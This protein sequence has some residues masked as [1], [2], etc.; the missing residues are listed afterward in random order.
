VNDSAALALAR[1]LGQY[2]QGLAAEPTRLRSLLQ[3]ECPE[4][5]RQIAALMQAIEEGIP[6]DLRRVHS[7]EPVQSVASRL[8]KRLSDNRALAR[9]A[10][11]WAVGAWANALGIKL[12]A[13]A[14]PTPVAR[15]DEW[16]SADEEPVSRRGPEQPR[17]LERDRE[18]A[19]GS[20]R[21]H[22]TIRKT[23]PNP[24][25]SVLSA[26]AARWRGLSSTVQKA[27]GGGA[28]AVVAIVGW[29]SLSGSPLAITR[30]DMTETFVGDG[31]RREVQMEFSARGAALRS[32]D[33]RFVRGD[34]NWNPASWSVNLPADAAAKGRATLGTMSF[35][36]QRPASATFE[37]VLVTADGRRSA[38]FEKTFEIQ[39][40]PSTP[41]RITSINLPGP[42]YVGR[43]FTANIAFEDPDGD[44]AKVERRVVESTSA[45]A[46]DLFTQDA[47]G[48]QG[49]KAG[50]TTYTFQAPKVPFKSTVEFVLIDARGSRSEP[51][52]VALEVLPA[53]AANTTQQSGSAAAAVVRGDPRQQQSQQPPQQQPPQQQSQGGFPARI[54]NCVPPSGLPP[55]QIPAWIQRNCFGVRR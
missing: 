27:V 17:D 29:V 55:Q 49:K 24:V 2:G 26:L 54:P 41:P 31:K 22:D 15:A 46:Q 5:K 51:R 43:D 32:V 45:W 37:Y 23:E 33:I 30:I 42:I 25:A 20:A 14:E 3:D 8:A 36:S 18:G 6:D 34:G 50:T 7:G 35:N 10:A 13:A 4:A 28:A 39:P 1:L 12:Q 19:N 40:A 53:P 9:E 21:G 44:V 52:R 16:A 38:P 47:V 11:E 48:T